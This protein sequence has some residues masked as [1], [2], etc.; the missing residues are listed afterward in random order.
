M[1]YT[2]IVLIIILTVLG[3]VGADELSKLKE[4]ENEIFRFIR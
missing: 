1:K 2:I 3:L 4:L